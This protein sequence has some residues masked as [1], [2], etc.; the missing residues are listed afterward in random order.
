[1]TGLMRRARHAAEADARQLRQAAEAG[2]V[3]LIDT[4]LALVAVFVLW[5]DP[6]GGV[7]LGAICILLGVGYRAYQSL[8]RRQ[9]VLE[10][11]HDFTQAVDGHDQPDAVLRATLDAAR[12]TMAARS[13]TGGRA[14]T[15]D[16][17]VSVLRLSWVP[18]LPSPL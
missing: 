12:V 9:S 5:V 3:T 11:I 7:L 16:P 14:T 8:R 4:C 2:L 13:A 1:M 15:I 10:R 18:S 17:T 6:L